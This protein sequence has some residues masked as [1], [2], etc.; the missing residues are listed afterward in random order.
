M[1]L[2]RLAWYAV[3]ALMIWWAASNP[4][5]AAQIASQIMSVIASFLAGIK[6]YLVSHAG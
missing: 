4:A 1:S 6:Q 2:S 5:E 3:I